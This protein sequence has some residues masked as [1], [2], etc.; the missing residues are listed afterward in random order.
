[1]LFYYSGQL[2]DNEVIPGFHVIATARRQAV[3][4]ELAEMGMSTLELDVTKSESIQ[5]AKETVTALTGG[6]LDVLVNNAYVFLTSRP[7]STMAP[8]PLSP[9]V[10]GPS[11]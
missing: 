1:M 10:Y 3:L 5:A 6:R 2:A 7:P 8:F 11:P 9:S 4:D